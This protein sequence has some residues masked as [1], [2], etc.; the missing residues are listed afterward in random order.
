MSEIK[1]NQNQIEYT[2]PTTRSNMSVTHFKI[3]G[4]NI[5]KEITNYQNKTLRPKTNNIETPQLDY[6]TL[7]M[8]HIKFPKYKYR[9]NNGQSKETSHVN[10]IPRIEK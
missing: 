6:L 7:E 8:K 9:N 5:K 10:A 4:I 1:Y 2:L 3:R